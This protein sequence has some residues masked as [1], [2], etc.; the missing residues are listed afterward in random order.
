MSAPPLQID[1]ADVIEWAWSPVG[2]G[3]VAVEGGEPLVIHGLAIARY[4][5]E[6]GVYRFACDREWQCVQDAD[7]A[8][9]AEAKERLPLQYRREPAQWNAR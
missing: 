8:S 6:R 9:V 2:F 5:S 1:G 4:R 7:Y 3:V